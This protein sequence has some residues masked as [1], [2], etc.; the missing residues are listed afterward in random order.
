MNDVVIGGSGFIGSQLV[1]VLYESGSNVIVVD[2]QPS[3]LGKRV[4][5]LQVDFSQF[6]GKV[7]EFCR[8]N[9][10]TKSRTR[11]WHLAAN[12]DIQRSISDYQLDLQ[13]TLGTTFATLDLATKLEVDQLIFTS[14]S[15]VYGNLDKE[16]AFSESSPCIPISNY[17]RTKWFSE[18]LIENFSRD[19]PPSFKYLI[20]RLPNVI[21]YPATH[22]LLFDLVNQLKADKKK[23][24]VLGD[25]SQTKQYVHVKELASIL[26]A[27]A[28]VYISRSHLINIAP[29]DS[30]ISVREIVS[31]L[32]E[33]VAPSAKVQFGTQ[34]F[35]WRGD[36]PHYVMQSKEL[37][38]F[39]GNNLMGSRNAVT[40]AIQ[41]VYVHINK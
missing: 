17:G 29:L 23:L 41:E 35:G 16:V 30:G 37:E 24:T 25:G 3:S 18:L 1:N 15:A 32:T 31:L 8:H 9:F 2:K 27:L 13:N 5:F 28:D 12:S 40:K 33:I 6:S 7:L 20:C 14:S 19:N 39:F 21:G 36:V 10:S 34:P 38:V 26:V 11:V 22:G 4:P